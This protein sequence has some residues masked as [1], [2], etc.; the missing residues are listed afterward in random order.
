TTAD[1]DVVISA[2]VQAGIRL[3]ET[4]EGTKFQPLFA[5]VK[6]VVAQT[7]VLPLRHRNTGV[8]VDVALG[9]SGFEQQ[10]IN[11][12]VPVQI[13]DFPIAVAT[14]EDLLIMKVFAGR[15]KDDQDARGIA[16]VRGHNLDWEY[17]LNTAAQL[18]EAVGQDLAGRIQTLK[19]EFG[20]P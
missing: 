1:V 11:R 9:M 12:A 15:P 4:L 8:K 16:T 6:D 13:A 10:L 5:G 19:T 14:A 7:F 3:A 2:D 17:C 20:G 18:G